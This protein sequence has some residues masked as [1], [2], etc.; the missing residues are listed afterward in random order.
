MA[1]QIL[2]SEQL[3][4]LM[5]RASAVWAPALDSAMQKYLINTKLRA[6]A[7]LAQIAVES[8]ELQHLE[9]SFVYTPERLLK[10]FPR[11]FPDLGTAN[12]YAGQ[13]HAIADRVYSGLYGNG[14]EQSGDGWTYRG[15]GPL[16]ITFKANYQACAKGLN[17]TLVFTCPD[18]LQTPVPGALSAAWFFVEH[19][20]LLFA[21]AGNIDAVTHRVTGSMEE[22]DVRR[23]YYKTALMVL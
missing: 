12:R 18:R 13:P 3:A 7:F 14:D 2:S 22:A 4:N 23:K 16:Q 10:V 6:A 8:G 11:E 17:D 21:D 15:R 1:D 19:G 20:C 5:P 9:E